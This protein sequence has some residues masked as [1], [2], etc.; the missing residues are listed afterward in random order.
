[1]TPAVR[2]AAAISLAGAAVCLFVWT[3]GRPSEEARI[4][5]LLE[6]AAAR[7]EKRDLGGLMDLFDP[8]Y[9]DFEGRDKAGTVRLITDY[10]AAYRGVVIHIL[11]VHP[12]TIGT[13]GRAEV[14]CEVALS[15]G[16][17]QV[18]RRLIRVGSEYYRF[19]FDLRKDGTGEW[20]F[21]YAE[22]ESI[23]LTELFPESLAVLKKLFPRL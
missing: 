10:L 2:R 12:G 23:G 9:A 18:L 6:D 19:R 16:A 15:H 7:A 3:C 13:D 4:R 11:G 21:A 5:E 8:G 20:R 14:E 1:V 22:W 17:A